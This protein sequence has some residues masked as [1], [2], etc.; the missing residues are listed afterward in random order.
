[1]DENQWQPARLRKVH[2]QRGIDELSVNLSKEKIKAA[3]RKIVRV[4]Q[5]PIDPRIRKDYRTRGCT[6]DRFFQV[7]SEDIEY[8]GTRMVMVCEH[9][10]LTD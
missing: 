1:M 9:E 6:A 8:E 7:N 10:I 3:L 4:R 2:D 5:C